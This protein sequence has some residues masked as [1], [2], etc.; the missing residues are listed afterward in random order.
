M[1]LLSRDKELVNGAGAVIMEVGSTRLKFAE[2]P[3][4][5]I[6]LN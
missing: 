4:I 1:S 3:N 5:R 6:P 2:V